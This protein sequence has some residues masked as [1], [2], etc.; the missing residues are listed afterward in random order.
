MKKTLLILS[1]LLLTSIGASAQ[2]TA[3]KFV[4]SEWGSIDTGRVTDAN[5]TYDTEAN[6]ISVA[7]GTGANNVALS[8]GRDNNFT[9]SSYTVTN[10]QHWFIV[11]GTNLSTADNASQLWWMNGANDGGSYEPTNVVN[12]SDGS[13]LLAWDLTTTGIDTNLQ[14]AENYLNGWTGFGLTS[15]TGTSVISDICFY[16]LEEAVEAYPSLDGVLQETITTQYEFLNSDWVELTDHPNSTATASENNTITITT[17]AN[18]TTSI[19]LC[20]GNEAPYNTAGYYVTNE[21]SWFVIVGTNLSTG[22]GASILWWMNGYNNGMQIAPTETATL[23]DGQIVLAW[24]LSQSEAGSY[25]QN[26]KNTLS[27]F[28]CLGLTSTSTTSVISD[29][30]F[31]T[32]D[33]A[34]SMIDGTTHFCTANLEHWTLT[35][36]DGNTGVLQQ[37]TWATQS[38]EKMST[39]FLEYYAAGD[40]YLS[41]ATIS[42]EQ[43]TGLEAGMYTV[44]MDIRIIDFA[45]DET[46][47]NA[48]IGT[49]TKFIA[50]G[51]SEDLLTGND[52]TEDEYDTDGHD[53][54]YGTYTL[55]CEVGEA[56]TLD[57]S[58]DIEDA[59][60]SWIMFKNLSVTYAGEVV[61]ETISWEMTDAKWGTIILPFAADVPSG[62]TAHSCAALEEDGT[63]LQLE[64]VGTLEANTPYILSGT[65]AEYTFSGVATNTQDSY[66]AGLL[67]GTFKEMDYSALS[68]LSGTVYL[69]QNHEGENGEEGEGVAFYPVTEA[70]TG[71]SLGANHCYLT[72]SSASGVKGFISF[73]DTGEATGIVA[74][75]GDDVIANDAIYDLSGRRVAKAVK[76]VYIQ[77]GKK[78]LVK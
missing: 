68:A 13:V 75:E 77:N 16:T 76:G 61:K 32:E 37:D 17:T 42:H 23:D 15:T 73:P 19:G 70:S 18:S 33:E 2:T 43:L 58:L 7:A 12:L 31:Y 45:Q 40:L 72:L 63:T 59:T 38:D 50:N 4:C 74:V 60:Y 57:I 14:N 69:L 71:A 34:H 30:N 78:M 24:D 36:T 48:K 56:G 1:A 49:G 11:V 52:G 21:Q 67:T 27:G 66:S 39:P 20:N 55:S 44:S 64:D 5:V 62:L 53:E 3:Y 47:G 46:G 8:N 25:L 29:I 65:A 41:D 51:V 10:E 26:E 9:T 54:V 35:Q 6:T 28:T 22:E